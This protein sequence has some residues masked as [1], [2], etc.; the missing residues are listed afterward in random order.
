MENKTRVLLTGASGTVGY[1][2]LKQLV[3]LKDN[4]S[5]TAFDVETSKSKKK[6]SAFKD[7]LE[8]VYGDI[9]KPNDLENITKNQDVVIHLAAKIPP[10][11]DD[12]PELAN[13]V[14]VEG[15]RNLINA[16]EKNSPDCFFL[17]SSSISVYGDRLKTPMIKV[18]DPLIPSKGDLY[19]KTK[20]E[21]EQ[22]V[23]NSKL[24]WSI[25]RLAAIMGG[26][27]ISKLMFEQPL[28]TSLEIA[29]PEDTGRAFVKAI[30]KQERLSKQIFNLGGGSSCR[31]SYKDFLINSFQI[32]GLGKLDFPEN[33]F[34]EKNFHCGFYEDGN[35]LARILHFRNDTLVDY[36]E[37]EI[38]KVSSFQKGIT[39][40]FKRPIKYFLLKK[41]EPYAAYKENNEKLKQH[42]FN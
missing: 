22:I 27:K 12:Q 35:E 10:I 9:S 30:Q 13:K 2:V 42:Y 38:K 34:A 6:F 25:F 40:I 19:A 21:A 18:S 31:L 4:F 16:L 36:F 1:E 15:T 39:S 7:K 14:N 8:I 26:H 33:S 41:S 28:D 3:E 20:I 17:Y 37:K 32:Y 5:V 11:A 29:T 24:D 23:Q